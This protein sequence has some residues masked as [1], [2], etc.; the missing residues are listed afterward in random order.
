MG[1][2][3]VRRDE[4]PDDRPDRADAGAE[5]LEVALQRGALA[6]G[7]R[8]AAGIAASAFDVPGRRGNV[9]HVGLMMRRLWNRPHLASPRWDRV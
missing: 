3:G 1:Q 6:H 9:D 7:P 2:I 5:V 8:R 4:I